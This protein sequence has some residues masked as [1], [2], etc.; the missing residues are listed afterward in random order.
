MH[1][2]FISYHHANDQF[3]K[4]QLLAWNQSSPL[5]L[6]YSVDTG[7]IPDHWDDQTIRQKIRDE[8]LRDS[9]VTILLVGT[10]TKKRK[11]IDWEIYS[12]MYDGIKNKKSGLLIIN[13]PSTG[14]TYYTAAHEEEKTKIYPE[15]TFWI[16]ISNRSDYQNRYPYMPER[17]IDNLLKKEAKVSVTNWSKIVSDWSNLDLMIENAY[18]ARTKCEY[19]LSRPMRR[20]NS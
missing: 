9:S 20:S 13:L 17:I 6:D 3:Y 18:N 12:S 2:V 16:S 4:E 15:N 14:C 8:Y 19:D 10:E 5:F 1:R 11:H 7:N